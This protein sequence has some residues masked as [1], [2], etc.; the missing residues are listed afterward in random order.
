MNTWYHGLL[1]LLKPFARRAA[2]K[3]H[4][5]FRAKYIDATVRCHGDLCNHDNFVNK[6]KHKAGFSGLQ[7]GRIGAGYGSSG[8]RSCEWYWYVVVV[9]VVIVRILMD[10]LMKLKRKWKMVVFFSWLLY[11][12]LSILHLT[13]C[14]DLCAGWTSNAGFKLP[15]CARLPPTPT[16]IPHLILSHLQPHL[17]LIL[18]D[19]LQVGDFLFSFT[20]F[21]LYCA[22]C[23]YTTLI[24]F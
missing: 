21:L 19:V 18:P 9:E 8:G 17:H 23:N 16:P 22:M 1:K 24:Q 13:R 14:K 4:P 10:E 3:P 6:C 15:I 20:T 5:S 11:S 7:P 12:P 2:D